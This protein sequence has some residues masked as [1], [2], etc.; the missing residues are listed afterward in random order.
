[1]NALKEIIEDRIKKINDYER[2]VIANGG[3][4]CYENQMYRNGRLLEL[5]FFLDLIKGD[6]SAIH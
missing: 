4:I 3:N 1:M 5:N 2:T 6:P